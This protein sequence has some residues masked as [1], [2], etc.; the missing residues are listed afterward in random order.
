MEEDT[1]LLSTFEVIL[2][3]RYAML[4]YKSHTSSFTYIHTYEFH[5]SNFSVKKTGT[6]WI[7]FILTGVWFC[8]TDSFF[9]C[10][11]LEGREEDILFLFRIR[12]RV[13]SK[14]ND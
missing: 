11:A 2:S 12:V 5:G 1:W 3:S 8:E 10:L 9:F 7:I 13:R 14:L 4:K 6:G